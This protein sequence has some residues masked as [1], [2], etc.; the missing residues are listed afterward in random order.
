[1]DDIGAAVPQVIWTLFNESGQAER[2]KD[3]NI[4]AVVSSLC[5]I[6]AMKNLELL[7]SA[8]QNLSDTDLDEIIE[9]YARNNQFHGCNAIHGQEIALE[10]YLDDAT[11]TSLCIANGAIT[12]V[13]SPD[14]EAV[15][16]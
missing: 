12:K 15:P 7:Q 5:Y 1:M 9:G 13:P 3:V 2:I 6:D 16:S 4:E 8:V 11:G 10:S 14:D